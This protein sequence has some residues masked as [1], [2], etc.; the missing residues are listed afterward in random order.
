MPLVTAIFC[1][2]LRAFR[3]EL[4]LA[5]RFRPIVQCASVV[6][7]VAVALGAF[8]ANAQ[9]DPFAQPGGISK[10]SAP[11]IL[12]GS[13]YVAVPDAEYRNFTIKWTRPANSG[14]GRILEYR[15]TRSKAALSLGQDP[16]RCDLLSESVLPYVADSFE[17]FIGPDVFE[18]TDDTN[19]PHRNCVRWHISARSAA[20]WGPAA[21]TNPLLTRAGSTDRCGTGTSAPPVPIGITSGDSRFVTCPSIGDLE[22]SDWCKRGG[23]T[24]LWNKTAE[25]AGA[26][27]REFWLICEFPYSFGCDGRYNK[28]YDSARNVTAC[29]LSRD[30][31]ER[32]YCGSYS[33]YNLRHRECICARLTEVESVTKYSATPPNI[34]GEQKCGCDANLVANPI[35]GIDTGTCRCPEGKIYYPDTHAC[36][37]E[38]GK[39]FDINP[40]GG[41]KTVENGV[42]KINHTRSVSFV[43]T[44]MIPTAVF[45]NHPGWITVQVGDAT[46]SLCTGRFFQLNVSGTKRI[47]RATC[48]AQ[49]RVGKHDIA[50]KFRISEHDF[51]APLKIHVGTDRQGECERKN[52][53]VNPVG[54]RYEPGDGTCELDREAFYKTLGDPAQGNVPRCF[55]SIDHIDVTTNCAQHYAELRAAGCN[56]PET[57]HKQGSANHLPSVNPLSDYSCVC[58]DTGEATRADGSCYSDQEKALIAEVKKPSPNLAT[59]RALLAH[60]DVNPNL[61]DGG[62]PLLAIAATLLHAE[63]VSVMITAGA[64]V[65]VKFGIISQL[66]SQGRPLFVPMLLAQLARS[67]NPLSANRRFVET[68]VHFGDAAGDKFNWGRVDLSTENTPVRNIIL[69]YMA[70]RHTSNLQFASHSP[71]DLAQNPFLERVGWYMQDRGGVCTTN[72]PEYSADSPV[73]AGRPACSATSSGI[74]SCSKCAGYPLYSEGAGACVASCDPVKER[75][76]AGWPDQLCECADGYIRID[77]SCAK[78]LR[79]EQ[80]PFLNAALVGSPGAPTV[81]LS[82]Q[83]P[84]NEGPPLTR[85][86]FRHGFANP[87]ANAPNCDEADFGSQLDSPSTAFSGILE[88][89]T[90]ARQSVVNYYGQCAVYRIAGVNA[91]GVGAQRESVRLYIQHPPGGVGA[92]RAAALP[93][94]R[95][96]LSWNAVSEANRLGAVISGYEV[97]RKT[98]DG[99]FVSVGF[100][101]RLSYVDN[102]PPLGAMVRYQVRAQSSAGA[103][104]LSGETSAILV[105]G[106]RIDYNAA[107]V[108]EL[109]RA[110]PLLATVQLYLFSGADAN[111]T[112]NGAPALLSAAERGR[113]DLVRALVAAGADVNARHPNVFD[114]NLAHLTANNNRDRGA[115]RLGWETA[116][117]VLFAFG[118]ALAQR[119]ASFDWN[120]R[121]GRGQ[122]PLEYF[123]AN[124]GLASMVDKAIIER[125][126]N[127]MIALGATCREAEKAEH[128][129]PKLCE[130]S[131]GPGAPETFSA[132][133]GGALRTSVT[134][135]WSAPFEN[136]SPI[137][138]YKFWRISGAPAAGESDCADYQFP[139]ITPTTPTLS[140][141]G[142]L[143]SARTAVD[144]LGAAGYGLCHRYGIA[145]IDENGEGAR[146]ESA[147]F[148]AQFK[149]TTLAPPRVAVGLDRVPVVS[150]D[151]LTNLQT[152]RRGAVI[153]EYELQ[154]RT[155]PAGTW[156][157]L[158]DVSHAESSYRD[159][160]VTAGRSYYYRIRTQSSAG[161]GDYSASSAEA[162]I[163]SSGGCPIGQLDADPG[164][165][166]NCQVIGTS[167][168]SQTERFYNRYWREENGRAECG[169]LDGYENLDISGSRYCAQSGEPG[170]PQPGDSENP[171]MIETVIEACAHASAGYS[172]Q[173]SDVIA[174]GSGD[175]LG[176]Q[177]SC[178]IHTR[179]V[180]P[181][182]LKEN[183]KTECVL[184]TQQFD[185]DARRSS[186]TGLLDALFCHEVFP[187]L[188]G[189]Q[190]SVGV[191][192]PGHDADNPYV[193]GECPPGQNLDR[194]LNR[195]LKNCDSGP[196]TNLG[197]GEVSGL[198]LMQGSSVEEDSCACPAGE[199]LDGTACVSACP[200]G[201][202]EITDGDGMTSCLD[203]ENVSNA[204]DH[205]GLAS[206][207]GVRIVGTYADGNLA[208]LCPVDRDINSLDSETVYTSKL[209]WLSASPGY[210]AALPSPTDPNH[211]P[212]CED[213][214]E[215]SETP[216]ADPSLPTDFGTEDDPITFGD[217]PEGKSSPEG[218][219]GADC[220]CANDN[221]IEQGRYCFNPEG[222]VTPPNAD[223]DALRELCEDAFRGKAEDAGNGQTVC[224]EVD[225]ND[226]FCIFGSADAFP[227]EGLLRHVR[228]C[229]FAGRP[230]RSGRRA[231]NP[232]FCGRFCELGYAAGD[233][234]VFTSLE[235]QRAHGETAESL[236][237]TLTV[238]AGYADAQL[239]T[240]N[241]ARTIPGLR[242]LFS[243]ELPQ[244]Y[245]VQQSGVLWSLAA[246]AGEARS[247][248][249]VIRISH[250]EDERVY[251][252]ARARLEWVDAPKYAT[253]TYG[254]DDETLTSPYVIP[255]KTEGSAHSLLTDSGGRG[256]YT[257][258]KI[259]DSQ[260]TEEESTQ[261]AARK[262]FTISSGSGFVTFGENPL[263][264]V[265]R[266]ELEVH[267]THPDMLGTLILRIPVEVTN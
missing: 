3:G 155:G 176:Y 30:V 162:M 91:L 126:S 73:C 108:A 154:R 4:S 119:G 92:V 80:A 139:P 63:V 20:G 216:G 16:A 34:A 107:L 5:P 12:H 182:G 122:R 194:D 116:R 239:Y 70:G 147:G 219:T 37:L 54:G 191:F 167:C 2:I 173:R 134:L 40:I 213:L 118:S 169:C 32:S 183:P 84:V 165:N 227:C 8:P 66:N 172:V 265:D 207:E 168:D 231:L 234:C 250:P 251:F 228:N 129:F 21:A 177:Q 217:C 210:K 109:K 261:N 195:C 60:S 246:N 222:R 98:D 215:E 88:G 11:I 121:D 103:G 153:T 99:N 1:G 255:R 36:A 14:G 59:V 198:E 253:L 128:E 85:Y 28:R 175:L 174:F 96:S 164:L 187:E 42:V 132:E 120:A 158:S 163:P 35:A 133:L 241:L 100:A 148:Y 130:G 224:S 146:A 22:A 221:E 123:D 52:P 237:T 180:N 245:S 199:V 151:R 68:F 25:E 160:N 127:Y 209:C 75:A 240:V 38:V 208:V 249:A 201:E 17:A 135:S 44:I 79:P 115:L 101:P 235:F 71:E 188:E 218:E 33:N 24:L 170:E 7:F 110:S 86:E 225:A 55:T 185:N 105:P 114:R 9:S 62:V 69:S 64:D 31:R 53:A 117:D 39:N 67:D 236:L 74:Y 205:C 137:T 50:A 257:L 125:M 266:Y 143:A 242:P 136:D 72:S 49:I 181:Q 145:A 43:L 263:S 223:K 192:P 48:E 166:N 256:E 243:V 45:E 13:D 156:A 78:D 184:A 206:G 83:A 259:F 87:G 61:S 124:Y 214:A 111:V 18:F 131:P 159:V 104:A 90:R 106:E 89:R 149:P 197:R 193:Y 161:P 190:A 157:K 19:I 258:R 140:I 179:R 244:L 29:G 138:G 102:Y 252:P 247:S 57:L 81:E 41:E 202:R 189:T 262:R 113:A 94:S 220:E 150:W 267:F 76:A 51:L 144:D 212:S 196:S 58:A 93:N 6:A 203:E 26:K 47:F 264:R 186:D 95:I 211:V 232:F 77:G 46:T 141:P 142:V 10:P 171:V 82:W 56:P 233:E 27:D 204:P 200:V 229:N 254:K 178:N 260:G 248:L 226:T 23:G 230:E 97:L 65:S 152:E 15:I 112:I 238:A